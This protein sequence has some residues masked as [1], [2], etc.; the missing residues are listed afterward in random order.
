MLKKLKR[1]VE[2]C[3]VSV[4]TLVSLLTLSPVALALDDCSEANTTKIQQIYVAYYGRPADPGGLT[5]WCGK[6]QDGG[7][8]NSIITAFGTSAEYT[9]R[10]GTLSNTELVVNLYQ[11]MLGRNPEL[12]AEGSNF[13]YQRL[14]S[15]A[16]NLQGIAIQ[17]LNGAL[18]NEGVDGTIIDY[19]VQIAELFTSQFSLFTADMDAAAVEALAADSF[20]AIGTLM[21][22][23][24]KPA[25]GDI[26]D[27][28]AA[29]ERIKTIVGYLTTDNNSNDVANYFDPEANPDGD[30]LPNNSDSYPFDASNALSFRIAG[31]VTLFVEEGGQAVAYSPRVNIVDADV[32]YTLSG[33]ADKQ[34]FSINSGTGEISFRTATD[35]E[36]PSDSDQNNFYNLDVTATDRNNG[37]LSATQTL[38]VRVTNVGPS[39]V[40]TS[41]AAVTVLENTAQAFYTASVVADMSESLLDFVV[42]D[43][44][45]DPGG[46]TD[47]NL[48]VIDI[49]GNISF[50]NAPDYETPGS[51]NNNNNYTIEL[52]ALIIDADDTVHTTAMTVA[53]NLQDI[54]TV[55]FT[56]EASVSVLDNALSG[57]LRKVEA[58]NEGGG[59]LSYAIDGGANESVFSLHGS[60]GE[61]QFAAEAISTIVAGN[62]YI[63]IVEA[64]I[65]DVPSGIRQQITV[66]VSEYVPPVEDPDLPFELT[67]EALVVIDEAIVFSHSVTSNK[68]SVVF[69]ISGGDDGELFTIDTSTGEMAKKQGDFSFASPEDLDQDNSYL[70]VITAVFGDET[71]VQS[72]QFVVVT[73]TQAFAPE[74]VGGNSVAVEVLENKVSTGY[75]VVAIDSNGDP[76]V[77]TLIGT[78]DDDLF[79]LYDDQNLFFKEAPDYEIPVDVGEDNVYNIRVRVSD[80]QA[81]DSQELVVT[82]GNAPGF[83]V[84]DAHIVEPPS[85]SAS[86]LV[87]NITIDEGVAPEG[88]AGVFFS[89]SNGSAVGGSDSDYQSL[90]KQAVAI[91][92]GERSTT[93]TVTVNADALVEGD[94]TMTIT[95]LD[96]IS[97][98][99]LG[100]DVEAIGTIYDTAKLNDT[101]ITLC[102]DYAFDG[103]S[104]SHDNKIACF[105]ADEQGDPIPA[106]QDAVYGLDSTAYNDA[107]GHAGFSFTKFSASGSPQPADADDWS[108]VQDN[109]TGLM[110]EVKTT[111]GGLRDSDN[112]YSWAS[113]SG[114]DGGDDGFHS[115]LGCPDGNCSTE[116]LADA[117][118]AIGL[119][120]ANDWRLPT[121][122]E[123]TSIVNYGRVTPTIDRDY[124]PNTKSTRYWSTDTDVGDVA[125]AW[126]VFFSFG[127][128][129]TD[130]KINRSRV[131]LVRGG[132]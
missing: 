34:L 113:S 109:N 106:G 71:L 48:F 49:D 26:S 60:S 37:A 94:E 6:L 98:I 55:L 85:G 101:G 3:V 31:A 10:Y 32:I 35:F 46:A 130:K 77:Y 115:S 83:V 128:S 42:Y 11:Q 95:L 12:D 124:F 123:L 118:N 38:I 93:A 107:D 65:N 125:S 18:N 88:G 100:A 58:V 57:L 86:E 78:V 87:F 114:N 127:Y 81:D 25:G 4:V 1:V 27:A 17:V 5:H 131:R 33:G 9:D 63:V 89:T 67:S 39:P 91:A 62:D 76:L 108:C 64:L 99:E 61:L 79:Y 69:S 44:R 15:G 84:S 68:S 72:H 111:D 52:F 97:N 8:V 129:R 50:V 116:K 20:E 80:G 122:N 14:D 132:K 126:Q 96:P 22:D 119:C 29:F 40:F 36:A 21:Q 92:A 24:L 73:T 120:G 59:V 2:Y 43:L 51:R 56:S 117:V 16:S 74:L 45:P 82:V 104:G 13:Y 112:T 90:V 75:Q 54:D 28:T 47:N 103:G 23:I 53:V 19:K 66:E 105:S 7:S 70:V 30:E 41:A 110:W 102:G 121:V